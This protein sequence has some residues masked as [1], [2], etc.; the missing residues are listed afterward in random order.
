MGASTQETRLMHKARSRTDVAAATDEAVEAP[1]VAVD[2]VEVDD[3]ET[4][5]AT[6][7]SVPAV[8]SLHKL[9]MRAVLELNR[10]LPRDVR[11]SRRMT[12]SAPLSL[13]KNPQ[14][15]PCTFSLQ[16]MQ[17]WAVESMGVVCMQHKCL[18]AH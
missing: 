10:L 15:I 13:N 5:A 9:H 17:R 6:N 8:V 2:D 4:A 12:T 18:A 16:F 1:E 14:R 11:F 3:V 7:S